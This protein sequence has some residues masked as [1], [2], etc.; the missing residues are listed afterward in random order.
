MLCSLIGSSGNIAMGQCLLQLLQASYSDCEVEYRTGREWEPGWMT[1][2]QVRVLRR[3]VQQVW[4]GSKLF[5]MAIGAPLR[6]SAEGVWVPR[7][8]L[9]LAPPPSSLSQ[10]SRSPRLSYSSNYTLTRVAR[11]VNTR[12]YLPV[13]QADLSLS[14]T[15]P[16]TNSPRARLRL[17]L[18]AALYSA[19]GTKPTRASTQVTRSTQVLTRMS[20]VYDHRPLVGS[21][22]HP[23]A[24]ASAA[25]ASASSGGSST[26]PP[27]AG[28]NGVMPPVQ[29]L[30]GMHPPPPGALQAAQQQQQ[31]QQQ[32]LPPGVHPSAQR[33]NDL[34][35]FVKAEFEQVAGESG[36][37]KAQ[38]E[39]YEAMSEYIRLLRGGGG[40]NTRGLEERWAWMALGGSYLGCC[41]RIGGC[42]DAAPASRCPARA[43]GE[44]ADPLSSAAKSPR[45]TAGVELSSW[46]Y[47]TLLLC[48][49]PGALL[50]PVGRPG[51]SQRQSGG[52]QTRPTGLGAGRR[53][54]LIG[55]MLVWCFQ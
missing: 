18:A 20:R 17:S 21:H 22:T 41:W 34:L 36:S 42:I 10:L 44:V 8:R 30:A 37:L 51:E 5:C 55:C 11:C 6:L 54:R 19:T 40:T 47:C 16:S 38:R 35:E 53:E 26:H 27:L 7:G 45:V 1:T 3:G 13:L 43:L 15:R 4:V 48:D 2:A 14:P 12:A 32:Q 50:Q 31:Q 39:E 25:A 49:L 33:L 52:L 28:S 24:L 23:S 46:G 9:R 29:Q